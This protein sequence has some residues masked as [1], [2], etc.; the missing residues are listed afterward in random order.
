M[1]VLFCTLPHS[2]HLQFQVPLVWALQAAGHEVCVASQP[3]VTDQITGAGM[4]AVPVGGEVDPSPPMVNDRIASPAE[5]G[6]DM[7]EMRPEKLTYDYVHGL[8]LSHT[9]FLYQRVC[10]DPMIEELVDFARVWQPDLVIWDPM[11]FAGPVVARV[12]GAAHARLMFGFDL[13]GR[14]RESY[15]RMLAERPPHQRDDP[16]REWL[17]GVM[18]R[19]GGTF[20][21]EMVVGQ[22]TLDPIPTSMRY[23]VNL[24][25]VPFRYVPY[26]GAASIPDWL[27]EPPERRRVCITLGV[28][29]REMFKDWIAAVGELMDA[30]A[31]LDVEVIATLNEEQLKE[32]GSVPDNVRVADYVPLNALLPSCSAIVHHAGS[33]TFTTAMIHGVP[34]LLIPAGLWDTHHKAQAAQESGAGIHLPLDSVTPAAIKDGLVRLLEEPSFA[35][36]AARTRLEMQSAP[37]PG[38]LVPALERLTA[39]HTAK[40]R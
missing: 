24:P 5:L 18:E 15:L 33:G 14:L 11:T 31:D 2:S 22:W 23:D 40:H 36:N 9:A 34:Q 28:T 1:R 25:Y 38:E 10:P 32:L 20:D 35:E 19:Y 26:G 39:E 8:F 12:T 37:T 6:M 13:Q 16:M 4:T 29:V 21:E 3:E 27:R 7:A 30:V 17:G